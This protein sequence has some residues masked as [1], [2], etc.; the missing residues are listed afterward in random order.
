MYSSDN[1]V[2]EVL[3]R[4]PPVWGF[5]CSLHKLLECD[6]RTTVESTTASVGLA[7]ACP[8]NISSLVFFSKYILE[9]QQDLRFYHV[10]LLI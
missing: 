10:V 9:P 1:H 3:C 6:H 4:L 8:N 2:P 5:P 7:Q